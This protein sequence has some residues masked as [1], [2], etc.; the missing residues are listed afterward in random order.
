M[1]M[2]KIGFHPSI[3]KGLILITKGGYPNLPIP[4][5][6][7]RFYFHVFYFSFGERINM[8]HYTVGQ[9]LSQEVLY[10]LSHLYLYLS[11]RFLHKVNWSDYRIYFIPLPRPVLSNCIVSLD[12]PT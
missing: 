2:M 10:Y 3:I 1:P 6:L 4:V 8:N 9:G 7:S 12:I 11:A 5:A